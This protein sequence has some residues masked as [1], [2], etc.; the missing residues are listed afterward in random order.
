[1][2]CYRVKY[3]L[4]ANDGTKPEIVVL[5]ADCAEEATERV[6]NYYTEKCRGAYGVPSIVS[7]DAYASWTEAMGGVND[8]NK[9]K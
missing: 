1:M 7:V 6:I 9:N 8:E 2:K 4:P 3:T 5:K